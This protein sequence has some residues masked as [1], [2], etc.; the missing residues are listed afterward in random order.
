MTLVCG[1]EG[2]VPACE[3]GMPAGQNADKNNS[4]V[5][6]Y[7]SEFPDDLATAARC[8]GSPVVEVDVLADEADTSVA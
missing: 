7:C 8:Q 3:T 6:R 2:R 5:M 1:R 4:A